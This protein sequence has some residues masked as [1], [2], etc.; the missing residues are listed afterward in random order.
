MSEVKLVAFATVAGNSLGA[1]A[2]ITV[3]GYDGDRNVHT[4]DIVLDGEPVADEYGDLDYASADLILAANGYIRTDPWALSGGQWAAH[5][6]KEIDTA[7]FHR[8][9]AELYRPLFKGTGI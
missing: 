9:T 4:G 5:V 3:I 2:G 1:D 6:S 7:E 8:Q